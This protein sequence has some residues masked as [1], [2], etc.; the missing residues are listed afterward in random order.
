MVWY[1][2]R[3]V[4]FAVPILLGVCL[5]TFLLFYVVTPPEQL[6]R[7][8]IRSK[9]PTQEQIKDWLK[10]KGYDKPLHEQFKNHVSALFLFQFGKSDATNDDILERIKTGAPK[11]LHIALMILIG[12]ELSAISLALAVA[13]FRGTYVDFLATLITV[14]MISV[15]YMVYLILGQYVFGKELRWF[16]MS[17]FGDNFAESWKFV[18]LPMVVGII[19]GIP[20]NMRLYRT[21]MLDEVNQDYVRTARAKGVGERH[22]LFGHVLKNAAIPIITQVVQQLPVLFLG[23]ILL[24]SFFSIPGL[25]GMLRDAIEG[26]DFAVVRSMTFIGTILVIIGYILTDICYALVDPR[27]R[28]E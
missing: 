23:S 16:P 1:I 2:I 28:L 18:L 24:E 6:A 4:L 26:Q 20:A 27:V 19:Y 17:G 21:F 8:N 12:V 9:T 7:A 25:G 5:L 22:I 14:F 11:S 13:Y 3:R 15:V 10:S